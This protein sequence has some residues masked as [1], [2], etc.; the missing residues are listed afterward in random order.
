[1]VLEP[2]G[3]ISGEEVLLGY[4]PARQEFLLPE[5]GQYEFQAIYTDRHPP[6]PS[7]LVESNVLTI[8]AQ[9]PPASEREALRSYSHD[10]ARVAQFD[11]GWAGAA[12]RQLAWA[13]W[14][15]PVETMRQAARFLESFP[16][17]AY[18]EPV[19]YALMW[20]LRNR[21]DGN[22]ASVSAEEKALYERLKAEKPEDP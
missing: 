11:P 1:V 3:E 22:R 9:M 21:I 15:V 18:A 5:P 2:D 8:E 7:T 6:S 16:N 12:Q 20:A 17:S 13:G 4:D 10:L 19:R 14:G